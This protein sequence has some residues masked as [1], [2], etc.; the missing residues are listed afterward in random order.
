MKVLKFDGA[1][2]GSIK[3]LQ[4]VKRIVE[5]VEEPVVVVV[6]AVDGITDKLIT[7]SN[8]AATGS[9]TYI[10]E[11]NDIVKIHNQMK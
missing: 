5:S 2:V 11:Y 8:L 6:S 7:T 1:S 10:D 9:T 3:N 4:Q